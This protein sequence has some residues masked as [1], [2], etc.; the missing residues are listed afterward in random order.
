MKKFLSLALLAML[1][2]SANAAIVLEDDFSYADGDLVGNGSWTNHSGSD[3]LI[4]VQSGAVVLEHGGGSREDVGATFATQTLGVL[5]ATF[6]LT[7]ND[8]TPISGGDYEYFAHF[9]TEGSFN[10]TSR[11]DAIESGSGDYTLGLATTSSTAEVELASAL[12]FGTTYAVELT[13][14]FGTGLSGLSVDGSAPVFSTTPVFQAD[15][16]RFAFRQS[17]SSNDETITIDN[18]AVSAVPEPSSLAVVGLGLFAF[19]RR[20]RV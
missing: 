1:A 2:G 14:D 10:F 15:L 9:M 12:T 13:Y 8:D 17:N 11:L 6:D 18:L 20:R 4:Q 3:S 19:A 7:V 5:T 16:N